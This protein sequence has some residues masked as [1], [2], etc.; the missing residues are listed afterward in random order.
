MCVLGTDLCTWFNPAYMQF[1]MRTIHW[2]I[3]QP[4]IQKHYIDSPS[5]ICKMCVK[6]LHHFN[7]HLA[8][9]PQMAIE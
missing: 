2:E 5:T 3:Y 4:P 8:S 9:L 7:H 1:D 6:Y